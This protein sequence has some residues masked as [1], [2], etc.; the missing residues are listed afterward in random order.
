MNKPDFK[1]NWFIGSI[2]KD[3]GKRVGP[4]TAPGSIRRPLSSTFAKPRSERKGSTTIYCLH[5]V[6]KRLSVLDCD[7]LFSTLLSF[8]HRGNVAC[9]A[10]SITISMQNV[11]TKFIPKTRYATHIAT[12]IFFPETAA[13]WILLPRACFPYQF[14]LNLFKSR[15]KSYLLH[16]SP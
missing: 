9:L 10:W 12:S 5:K 6:Q 15:D 14:Y 4:C 13:L 3:G 2:T 16:I 8:S 11:Q 7:E 1:W